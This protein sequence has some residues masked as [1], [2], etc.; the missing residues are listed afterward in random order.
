MSNLYCTNKKEEKIYTQLMSELKKINEDWIELRKSNDYKIGMAICRLWRQLKKGDL[1]GMYRSIR[2]WIIGRRNNKASSITSMKNIDK[3]KPNYFS[4]ERIAIYTCIYGGYDSVREPISVPDNC[5][6][7]IFTEKDRTIESKV[8]IKRDAPEKIAKMSNIEKNR[9]I[10][11]HPHELFPEYK[12]S[13]YIDGNVQIISDLTEY[14]NLLNDIGIAIH[15]HHLRNC[16]YDEMKI[17]L[18]S[19]RI[20][21]KEGNRHLEYLL[22]DGMPK[23]YGLLQCNV[24]VRE[25]NNPICLKIMEEWWEEFMRYSKRDQISLPHV[26]YKNKIKVEQVGV[27]GNNIYTNPSFR[28]LLH[29]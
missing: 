10:K 22:N 21:P 9:Y 4:K 28:I 7:F 6:F 3:K 1:K 13:I 17:V 24:I 18:K 5:D 14:V 19:K 25:H 26:L 23:N 29:K 2:S 20:K 27:L 12:Y 15:T 11:M 8:W 16:V